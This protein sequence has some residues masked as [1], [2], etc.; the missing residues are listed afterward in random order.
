MSRI[1]PN[2]YANGY[3]GDSDSSLA[4]SGGEGGYDR[5]DEDRPYR[6]PPP[7]RSNR[8]QFQP[9]SGRR[10]GGYVAESYSAEPTRAG[11]AN[12][13]GYDN[14]GMRGGDEGYDPYRTAPDR[15]EERE[16][17][18][19]RPTSLERTQAKRRSGGSPWSQRS[20]QRRGAY[21]AGDG[22]RAIED[23]LNQIKR[24]FD[25]MTRDGCIPVEVALRLMDDSSLGLARQYDRFEGLN[26]D[27]QSALRMIVNEHHQGFNSSIGTFHS[28]QSAIVA[29]QARLRALRDGLTTAKSS[30]GTTKPELRGLAVASREYDDCLSLLGVIE[31]LQSI[32]ERLEA[33]ISEK[34]FLSAVELLQDALKSI[35]KPE[36]DGIGAL[37]DLRVYLSN[38]EHSLTDILIEELHNHLYL[39]S[40]Y[41]EN[42]WKDY[43]PQHL[44]GMGADGQVQPMN[45]GGRKLYQFLDKV[46]T[47]RPMQDDPT[48]NPEAD[49][50][51]YI[52]LLVESLNSLGRLETAVDTITQRLPV[53]LFRVVERSAS[54]VDQRHPASLRGPKPGGDRFE[55]IEKTSA[56]VLKD[57]L[58]VLYA[59]FEAIAEGHRVVHEVIS[60]IVRREDLRSAT[61][62]TIGFRELWKLYQSEIRSLLHDYLATDA[63][64]YRSGQG[65]D[66]GG[67]VFAKRQRDKAKKIFKLK[68]VDVK[69][70]DVTSEKEDLDYILKSSVPGLVEGK[71]AS[72]TGQVNGTNTADG[73]ATGHKLLVEASV[74]NMG[75]L[76]P[77][78]LA[79]LNRLREV[80]PPTS[81]IVMSTLTSFLDDFLI[82][83][84]LPQMD[85]TLAEL[86]AQAFIEADA[87]HQDPHWSMHAKKP[88]FKGAAKFLTLIMA[89]CRMLDHLPHDQAFSQLIISQMVTYYDKCYGWYKALVSRAQPHPQTGKRLK[90]AA[91]LTEEGELLEVVTTL[92][93]ADEK[94]APELIE[95]ETAII[96][97]LMDEMSLDDM[98]VI[99]DRR[100]ISALCLLYTS[101]RWL[102]S[103]ATQLR[104]ISSQ[105]TDSARRESQRPNTQR[106][107]TLVAS[108]DTPSESGRV[109]L[110]LSQE[111]AVAFDGVV[112]SYQ[113]LASTVLR[114]L[115]V[116]LRC[117]GPLRISRCISRTFLLSAPSH[118]PDPEILTLNSTIVGFD[119]ELSTHLPQ[120]Q[121]DFVVNGFSHLI[122]NLLVHSASKIPI[123]N[124]N[125]CGR[126]QL[127][128]LVLQQNLK[129]VEVSASLSKTALYFDLF[130]AGPDTVVKQAKEQANIKDG[131]GI[132]FSY[133]EMKTL[134]ELCFSEGCASE[135]REVAVQAK[136]GLDEK[137]LEL[138]EFLW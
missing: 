102:S 76:L 18:V 12:P 104:H 51:E 67:S 86:C 101:M 122:D 7:S 111:S 48:R 126:L 37:S 82:N 79:F 98:D 30:L 120:Q 81:D 22:G 83:V 109:Y 58:G 85:E 112:S 46:D 90:A 121:H 24:E 119:E 105:A 23:V 47:S 123:M 127:D 131:Q 92:A 3:G 1:R 33:R 69:S 19:A 124:A 26:R 52:Q 100:N 45:T 113:Q 65:L 137:L 72:D 94:S 5:S 34:R 11:G 57:L 93:Q 29:S 99:S 60:G 75:I 43:A 40:P 87:F 32:P 6:Q 116:E 14:A 9:R 91:A 31:H 74:F 71:R 125:G 35:R 117:H 64:S 133:A 128:I 96:I 39:K 68:D 73:G 118:E 20:P 2:L 53:E 110:P 78:S 41:C 114:T 138:S 28:I 4:R 77:P 38:Q 89:F 55:G 49:T 62:L 132:K 21:G 135:R 10:A 59:R 8:P 16:P 56:P 106:R 17:H 54:D 66:R 42:R 61:N 84:F 107:W 80:V 130:A 97:K 103:R 13:Y 88:I 95:K 70:S 50:F 27:L 136:R 36:M 134:L 115:H 63:D 25:F 129:N 15:D 108:Q 44:K